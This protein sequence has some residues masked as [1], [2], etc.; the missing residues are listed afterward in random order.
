MEEVLEVLADISPSPVMF[1]VVSG[2]IISIFPPRP[3]DEVLAEIKPF[4]V[5]VI[6]SV[7]W[8]CSRLGFALY[9]LK[10]ILPAGTLPLVS[11]NIPPWPNM[12]SWLLN[13]LIFPPPG[14]VLVA[15]SLAVALIC[16]FSPIVSRGE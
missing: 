12:L 7:D 4:S 2:A 1:S 10:V 6:L 5:K 15:F 9:G 13:M 3:V 16:A 14:S 11:A 8:V